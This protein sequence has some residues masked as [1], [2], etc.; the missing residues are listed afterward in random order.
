LE[1][2]YSQRCAATARRLKIRL[3]GKTQENSP[4]ID[5][6][7]NRTLDT[8]IVSDIQHETP[9]KFPAVRTIGSIVKS[10]GRK[11]GKVQAVHCGRRTLPK[12]QPA[13]I[14]NLS[15]DGSS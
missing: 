14:S 9:A 5:P 3:T 4:P 10:G 6:S 11:K 13:R 2:D 12:S 15:E 1:V 8:N 7:D